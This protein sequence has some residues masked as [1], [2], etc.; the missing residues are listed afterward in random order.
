MYYWIF[1]RVGLYYAS[2]FDFFLLLQDS[3]NKSV[4]I[5]WPKIFNVY[6]CILQGGQWMLNLVDHFG[7][8][9]LIFTLGILELMGILWFYGIAIDI[10]CITATQYNTINICNSKEIQSFPFY[11]I[12]C[13]SELETNDLLTSIR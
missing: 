10:K 13:Q 1:D 7:G 2:M 8:T 11:C 12:C 5:L 3:S 6:F 4:L 9:L